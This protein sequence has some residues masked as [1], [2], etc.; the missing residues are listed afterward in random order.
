MIA[1][2]LALSV[3]LAWTPDKTEQVL[4][5]SYSRPDTA[6]LMVQQQPVF[7][8]DSGPRDA[9]VV[10]L[11][12]GFGSSLQTWDD[13]APALEKNWRVLRLDIPGFGL[14]GPAVNHDYSDAADVARVIALLDQLG[15]QQV[16]IAGHSMGGRIAWNLTAAHPERVSHLVLLAPDG[17]S[18]PNA[19]SDH[20]YEVPPWLGLM[21][22]SLPKWALRM[23]GVAPAFADDSQLTPPMMQR[24]HDMMLAPGVR[25]ALLER[26]RQTR[27]S[28]PLA[29]LQAIKVPV[30]LLW[31]EKDAFIP[32]SNA[33]DYLKAMPQAKLR[34]LPGVGH[35]LH[36]EAPQASVQAVQEFLALP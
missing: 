32:L 36:E 25:A 26:M 7:V 3:W 19:K 28:D 23:G 9:P 6:R 5:Q 35:V 16:I 30:L 12:H 14:S 13:W 4:L 22:Y 34:T 27:N 15:I 18:D 24:Y 21:K 10:L 2:L 11:L 17:F 1:F 8:Q 29:R 33:Q 20:T 31:G